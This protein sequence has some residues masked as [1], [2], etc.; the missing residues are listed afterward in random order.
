MTRTSKTSARRPTASSWRQGSARTAVPQP[1]LL[2]TRARVPDNWKV[3]KKQP[4]QRALTR[5][6]P[7]RS[8][9]M[10]ANRLEE[11]SRRRL[12]EDAVQRAY[13]VALR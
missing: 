7:A 1:L 9:G 12:A 10:A 6:G 4:F 8:H 13:R 11:V 3:E 2:L 5:L